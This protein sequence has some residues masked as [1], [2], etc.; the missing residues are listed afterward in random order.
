MARPNKSQ[1]AHGGEVPADH[2]QAGDGSLARYGGALIGLRLA[3]P[4]RLANPRPDRRWTGTRLG[5]FASATRRHLWATRPCRRMRPRN[6]L[7]HREQRAGPGL[8]LSHRQGGFEIMTGHGFSEPVD[9]RAASVRRRWTAIAF[10]P[11]R[12]RNSCMTGTF[13][14]A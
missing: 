12:V 4:S 9:R 14:E 7:G 11:T 2:A 10:S 1:G 8:L 6:V 3:G 5:L 13:F